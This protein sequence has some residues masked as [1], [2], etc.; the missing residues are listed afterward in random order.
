MKIWVLALMALGTVSASA[1]VAPVSY[2][3][4]GLY[5]GELDCPG[6]K[7]LRA[8]D[9]LRGRAKIS[10]MDTHGVARL[11]LSVHTAGRTSLKYLF[12][13]S[14]I[15]RDGTAV[16]GSFAGNPIGEVFAYFKPDT[17]EVEV[18]LRDSSLT[19][20]LRIRAR[21]V[22]DP[23]MLYPPVPGQNPVS[24]VDLVG[25][26]DV[27]S[28]VSPGHFHF[29]VSL[30]G[31]PRYTASYKPGV[32]EELSFLGTYNQDFALLELVTPYASGGPF[33]KW[34]LRVYGETLW[35]FGY[36]AG[37]GNYQMITLHRKHP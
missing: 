2:R 16:E 17:G 15:T 4:E 3:L 9:A 12:Y 11:V 13:R 34:F 24:G 18:N 37:D 25:E 5:E 22:L 8:C 14:E 33:Q 19:F 20:D 1:L 7:D 27:V 26:Y 30:G 32:G 6:A 28:P 35:G 10:L 21:R 31:T 29:N 36:S 23:Q